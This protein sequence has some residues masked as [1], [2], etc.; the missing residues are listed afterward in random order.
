MFDIKSASARLGGDVPRGNRLLCPGP[1]HSKS[2]RS[3]SVTFNNDGTFTTH[4][5]AGDDFRDCRDHVKAVLGLSDDVPV[6]FR[7]EVPLFD[8]ER[9]RKQSDAFSIWERS[10]PIVDTPAETYLQS[11]RLSYGGNSLRYWQGGRAMVALITDA[12]S[13]EPIGLHRT[14]L[15]RNGN[16][17]AK[18]MLGGASGGVVRISNDDEVVSGLAIAEGIETT[19]AA[20][21]LGHGPAWACLSAGNVE[22]F[23]V[24][25]GIGALTIFADHDA[26]GT[27]IRV[28]E[29]CARRWHAAGREVTITISH[30]LGEDLAD[31]AERAA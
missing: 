14:F 2:D 5:F 11:R 6:A 24:L 18:K 15:D 12:V 26:S 20:L 30:T 29:A 16:R 21:R 19:L 25:N 10:V 23:P 31:V 7:Y 17:T 8:I 13:G 1:G 27:G 3:L 9:L 4:S 28:A 22:K